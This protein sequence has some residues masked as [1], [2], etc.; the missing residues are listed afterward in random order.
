MKI[1]KSSSGIRPIFKLT[2]GLI[3]AGK[4]LDWT[5]PSQNPEAAVNVF[6]VFQPVLR[7]RDLVPF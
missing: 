4:S 6:L 2:W 1:L 3:N 5:K 7:I